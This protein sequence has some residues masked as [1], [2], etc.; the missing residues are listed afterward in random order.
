MFEVIISDSGS[1]EIGG[2]GES[3]E[4]IFDK[5]KVRFNAAGSEF[6]GK[7]EPEMGVNGVNGVTIKAFV[8]FGLRIV[9]VGEIRAASRARARVKF[10]KRAF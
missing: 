10:S 9:I 7:A 4:Q 2:R 8:H 3:H 6:S 5:V 1:C